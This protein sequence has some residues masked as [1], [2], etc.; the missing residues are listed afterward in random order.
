MKTSSKI[1]LTVIIFA[2]LW[3]AVRA[4][5]I[6]NGV[7]NLVNEKETAYIEKTGQSKKF[8]NVSAI[9]VYAD[10]YVALR[11]SSHRLQMRIAG[12]HKQ[13]EIDNTVKD[14]TL[15]ITIKGAGTVNSRITYWTLD[16]PKIQTIGFH[17]TSEGCPPNRQMNLDIEEYTGKHLVIDATHLSKI[18]IENCTFEH[19]QINSAA[20]EC[21]LRITLLENTVVSH[22][23]VELPRKGTM[24]LE[25]VG[26]ASNHINV[27]DSLKVIAPLSGI[28]S[29][30]FD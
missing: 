7:Q 28:Y 21:P 17:Q 15:V 24:V 9:K 11:L 4:I 16:I 29:K 10:G 27:G 30:A 19:L 12:N 2:S 3:V 14:E 26:S 18:S 20:M 5:I 1:I 13:M 8:E 23:G 22:L 25:T 6:K